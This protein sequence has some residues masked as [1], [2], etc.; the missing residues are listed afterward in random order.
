LG[1]FYAKKK[2]GAKAAFS[3]QARSVRVVLHGAAAHRRARL[4]L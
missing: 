1:G 3:R 2:G 4:G